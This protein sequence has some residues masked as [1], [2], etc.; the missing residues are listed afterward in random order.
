MVLIE[1]LAGIILA[2]FVY[3]WLPD[4]K[5]KSMLRMVALAAGLLVA[6]FSTGQC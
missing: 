4:C 2:V 3:F 6:A 1:G 5:F